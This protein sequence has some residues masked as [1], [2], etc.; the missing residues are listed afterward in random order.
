MNP[1]DKDGR[2]AV[3]TRLEGSDVW[4]L[5]LQLHNP[6]VA[7][8]DS[9]TLVAARS[10]KRARATNLNK[11]ELRAVAW[12]AIISCDGESR[13][14][15]VQQLLKA[16]FNPG[17]QFASTFFRLWL[18]DPETVLRLIQEIRR[19]LHDPETL[20]V[21]SDFIEAAET[22]LPTKNHS[23]ILDA[24]RERVKVAR[25]LTRHSPQVSELAKRIRGKKDTG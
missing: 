24:Q 5:F 9:L 11:G 17:N 18:R 16:I 4:D 20:Q 15:E 6:D 12:F 10:A 8:S 25:R 3:K 22:K 13:E 2:K 21:V 1:Q 19:N 7:N 14:A 23:N